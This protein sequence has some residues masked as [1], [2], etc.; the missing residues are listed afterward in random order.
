MPLVRKLLSKSKKRKK[1]QIKI[2]TEAHGGTRLTKLF[3]KMNDK[4]PVLTSDQY[5]LKC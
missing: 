4:K 5:G 2:R 1:K 3:P